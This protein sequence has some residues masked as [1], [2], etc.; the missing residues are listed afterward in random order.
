MLII[1]KEQKNALQISLINRQI[2]GLVDHAKNHF[3]DETAG[4][5]DDELFDLIK[6]TLERAEKYDIKDERDVYKYINISMLYG[7]DFDE[8]QETKW[9][10]DYLSDED[11]SSPSKRLDRLYQEIVH[12]FEID[13]KNARIKKEF[14]SERLGKD[15][16]DNNAKK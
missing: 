4:K 8:Q 10:V 15:F 1:R 3:P 6:V 12:R 14:Y 7:A 13:E 9:T 2:L 5:T 16:R 11:V